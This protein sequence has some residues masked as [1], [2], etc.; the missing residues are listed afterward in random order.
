MQV[1]VR[2]CVE[3][4]N[5]TV[6]QLKF[7]SY[8]TSFAIAQLM[9]LVRPITDE[10]DRQRQDLLRA[11]AKMGENGEVTTDPTGNAVWKGNKEEKNFR[12]A[13]RNAL[14]ANVTIAFT[15]FK[16]D[17]LMLRDDVATPLQLFALMPFCELPAVNES[18]V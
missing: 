4:I 10:Y 11:N 14:D 3:L 18:A 13:I 15:P 1:T 17:S 12:E 6:G 2:A 8:E 16:R 5:S 7:E 9:H